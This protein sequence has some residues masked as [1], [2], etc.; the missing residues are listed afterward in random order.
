MSQRNGASRDQRRRAKLKKRA[1]KRR[2]AK[3]ETGSFMPSLSEAEQI[4][5]LSRHGELRTRLT[6]LGGVEPFEAAINAWPGPVAENFC[7]N[8]TGSIYLVGDAQGGPVYVAV[9]EALSL[10]GTG[11]LPAICVQC[12][13]PHALDPSEMKSGRIQILDASDLMLGRKLEHEVPV[14]D[15]TA[16]LY[17]D[18]SAEIPMHHEFG[19]VIEGQ[20]AAFKERFGRDPGP[21]DPIFYDPDAPGDEP[22]P[23]SED[24]MAE[25]WAKVCDLAEMQGMHPAIIHA[26]RTTGA[27][28][29]SETQALIEARDPQLWAD[30]CAAINDFHANVDLFADIDVPLLE[31]MLSAA[32]KAEGMAEIAVLLL[33]RSSSEGPPLVVNHAAEYG[34]DYGLGLI[35]STAN[36]LAGL[37][38]SDERLEI[39]HYEVAPLRGHAQL[40][41]TLTSDFPVIDLPEHLSILKAEA[42]A[43]V[44]EAARA[45]A[46]TACDFVA[47]TLSSPTTPKL[48]VTHQ[49]HYGG[50]E[51]IRELQ[52]DAEDCVQAGLVDEN[53]RFSI[54]G[55]RFDP[56][57]VTI[58]RFNLGTSDAH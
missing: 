16:R 55:Y 28:V 53:D 38:L 10:L 37:L 47:L 25:M 27:I 14:G 45:K 35:A 54:V 13:A 39:R 15:G 24:Q 2:A 48:L 31:G 51:A 20:L 40:L 9:L 36:N 56:T 19:E 52:K 41:K 5:R 49:A 6:E 43:Q 44:L 50:R 57:N 32:Q 4:R 46:E 17:S 42:D 3:K 34:D 1:A 7:R 26:M 8:C 23:I 12:C 21:D 30:W 22:V 33:Y 11:F 29:T 18:G 58:H